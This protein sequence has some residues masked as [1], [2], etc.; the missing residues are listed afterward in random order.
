MGVGLSLD[1]VNS[2]VRVDLIFGSIVC[3]GLGSDGRGNGG[4]NGNL[5]HFRNILKN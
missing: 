5:V 4:E 3:Y 2:A 1:E